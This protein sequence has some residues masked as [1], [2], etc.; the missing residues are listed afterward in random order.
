MVDIFSATVMPYFEAI[1][2][3]T[4]N[5]TLNQLVRD[6]LTD[7]WF[8]LNDLEQAQLLYEAHEYRQRLVDQRAINE[9]LAI[10]PRFPNKTAHPPP[11]S[12]HSSLRPAMGT[13][14]SQASPAS[15]M[16]R[17]QT[18]SPF[19]QVANTMAEFSRELFRHITI[20][21]HPKPSIPLKLSYPMIEDAHHIA[22][23]VAEAYHNRSVSSWKLIPMCS[24][25]TCYQD[26]YHGVCLN[27]PRTYI[28]YMLHQIAQKRM[29]WTCCF[30]LAT[31]IPPRINFWIPPAS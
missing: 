10:Q 25:L 9:L 20:N 5:E 16:T 7:K 6:S 24:I 2:A 28:K 27:T 21:N 31:N 17:D 13:A 8:S 15:W 23:L 1:T 4:T 19:F 3:D 26:V 11:L 14:P 29:L 22:Q 30:P 18:F 12:T